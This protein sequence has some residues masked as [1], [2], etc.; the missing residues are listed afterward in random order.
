MKAKQ[1]TILCSLIIMFALLVSSFSPLYAY[2]PLVT[3]DAGVGCKGDLV[4]ETGWETPLTEKAARENSFIIAPVY[5]PCGRLELSVEVP[6]LYNADEDM[7]SGFSDIMIAGKFLVAGHMPADG[8]IPTD[9][10][11]SV[12]GSMKT[13]SGD[14]SEDLGTGTREYACTLVL[15]RCFTGFAM[16]GMFG[17]GIPEEN[18]PFSDVEYHYGLA[19]DFFASE[20]I[21]L[22]SE[23]TGTASLSDGRIDYN[24]RILAGASLSI[25]DCA[26]L[27]CA[28]SAGISGNEDTALF[29]MGCSLLF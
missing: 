9:L 29:S 24:S 25:C 16:H 13:A 26:I 10:L 8:S 6:I 22:V 5:T 23:I 14:E 15:S 2:R 4:I 28:V 21:N 17:C 7:N 11:F 20:N 19:V 1:R 27:D 3:E 12:K 18:R